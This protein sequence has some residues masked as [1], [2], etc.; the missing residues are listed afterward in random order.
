MSKLWGGRFAGGLDPFFEAFNR[1]LPFDRRMV[2][3]DLVGSAA[4]ARALG[5]AGV[6][7]AAE[8]KKLEKALATLRKRVAA[9]PGLCERAADEDVHS[10]VERELGELVGTLAKKLHTG[11]SRNDQVATDLRLWMK[12]CVGDLD[13]AMAGLQRALVALAAKTSDLPVPGYTHLQR[14]QPVTAGHHALAYAEMLD[15]DRGRVADALRRMDRSPLGCGALAGTAFPVDRK[16]LAEDL[17]FGGPTRNSLDTVSDRDHVAE[18]LFACSLTMVHLSR[19]AEDWIFL[20]TFESRLVRFADAV[21]TGSSL[22]PQKKNPDAL[23]LIRG[24]C[25]RIAG[26]LQALL[27]TMKGLPL[28]YDKD[29]QEDKE[30]LFDALDQTTACVRV[31]TTV[32][33]TTEY[34]VERCRAAAA[35]GYLN[36]TDLADLLVLA[37]VPFR[38][39][40]E[41]V[42]IAVRTAIEH[43][44]ELE[45]LPTDVLT[46]LMPEIPAASLRRELSV[47]RVLA[48]RKVFGGTAP[49]RVR[50]EVKAWQKRLPE[51]EPKKRGR[52]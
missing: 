43:G 12:R 23:E 52:R 21:A 6:L 41:R 46:D 25:G 14:A 39:A 30:G 5:R 36:A 40:H 32:V 13:L 42:G 3:E 47:E 38:D 50:A 22:M 27:M 20:G 1:S 51:A 31:M 4:W 26:H 49:S 35:T 16:A 15:R 33:E 7:T 9:D 34:D 37:G 48:R 44:C 18:V 8:V 19:L 28:A 24:K 11:R 45:D 17:G 10:F 29:L 2:D